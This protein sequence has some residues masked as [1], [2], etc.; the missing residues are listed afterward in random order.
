MSGLVKCWF[1][2]LCVRFFYRTTIPRPLLAAPAFTSSIAGVRVGPRG[3][4][5]AKICYFA[6]LFSP[7]LA[8]PIS[9]VRRRKF[10]HYSTFLFLPRKIRED[11]GSM[12][13]AKRVLSKDVA[14]I[15]AVCGLDLDLYGNYLRPSHQAEQSVLDRLPMP[16][17]LMVR[18][19]T[20]TPSI[21]VRILT[22]HP[23]FI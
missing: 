19:R 4:L 22:G 9:I 12:L 7:L 8:S 14:C 5:V 10:R 15:E 16:R 2:G 17:R 20:L 1:R 13:T 18:L 6:G 21:E 3:G 11:L 23:V